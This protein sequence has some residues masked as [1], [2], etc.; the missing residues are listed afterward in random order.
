[1]ELKTIAQ[2]AAAI[3]IAATSTA[4]ADQ[5]AIQTAEP[6]A[7]ANERL[8]GALSIREV[9]TVEING[10]HFIVIEARDEGYV[11]AYVFAMNIDATGLYRLEADWDGTGLSSLPLQ[12][13]G[14]FLHET[15]CAF[16]TS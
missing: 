10:V 15:A 6:V 1:M 13:R 4:A 5:F 3:L 14:P 12:A 7:S 11:E 8:L 2:S 9:D 16:C